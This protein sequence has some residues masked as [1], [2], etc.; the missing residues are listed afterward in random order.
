MP[1][2]SLSL[3]IM[4]GGCASAQYRA[5]QASVDAPLS[6]LPRYDALGST[7]ALTPS[8]EQW[9][10]YEESGDAG[11]VLLTVVL[12]NGPKGWQVEL[13]RRSAHS[14]EH[15]T[16]A[17]NSPDDPFLRQR[18]NEPVRSLAKAV[19]VPAGRFVGV[20]AY[21]QSLYHPRVPIHGLLRGQDN[22]GRTW[23]L[24]RFGLQRAPTAR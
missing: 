14:F 17:L 16:L 21:A 9:A 1:R 18:R 8:V 11:S 15:K 19:E 4:L 2:A 22:Q 24:L 12:R 23:K 5:V 13:N 7:A 6:P 3:I 20:V 10:I